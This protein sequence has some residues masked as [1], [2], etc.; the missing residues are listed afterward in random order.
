MPCVPCVPAWS[1]CP[2]ATVPMCQKR[3]NFS[4]LRA[5]VSIYV[6]MCQRRA[7]FSNIFQNKIF[8]NFWIFQFCLT[9]ENF[10]NI[11]GNSRK[12]ISHNKGS[13]FWH[14]QNFNQVWIQVIKKPSETTVIVKGWRTIVDFLYNFKTFQFFCGVTHTWPLLF[15]IK[16]NNKND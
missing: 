14:L 3:A 2:L 4:F 7:N 8:F 11:L 1:K 6:P 5:N 15:L 16:F 9:S 13:E 10:K 12:F